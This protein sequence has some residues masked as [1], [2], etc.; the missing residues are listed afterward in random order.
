M[1]KEKGKEIPLFNLVPSII[2][3]LALCLGATSIRYALEGKF[4]AAAMLIIMAA[5]I[6]GLDGRV[7]RLLNST[8]NFGAQLDSLADLVN[9]GVAPGI[10]M[11]LWSLYQIPYK[12]VGWTVVLFYIICASF[13]LARFNTQ[14]H[15]D[16]HTT[17]DQE[18]M[19]NFFQGVPMP[20]A[21]A[22]CI[23][24]LIMTFNNISYEIP[25][26][27][28]AGYIVIV[29]ILMISS[30]PTLSLKHASINKEYVVPILGAVGLLVAGI[31][32]DPWTL[33]PALFIFYMISI[34]CAAIYFYLK[35][36]LF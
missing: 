26:I 5:V 25:S 12:G 15:K 34:P 20:A 2:T 29:G 11:Y 7:A 21:A 14:M 33:L 8:S 13:R 1:K 17:Q 32:I 36:F 30:L 35:R 18:E 16:T 3:M 24:P 22:I 28:I 31:L 4:E 23:T 19:K 9:F 27:M 6:D 10:T